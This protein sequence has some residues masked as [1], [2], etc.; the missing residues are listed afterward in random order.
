MSNIGKQRI[1]IPKNVNVGCKAWMLYAKGPY[2]EASI[3]FPIHTKITHNEKYLV[4][5]GNNINSALYGSLQR[6]LKSL[7]YGL[8]FLYVAHLKLVGVG[9]RASLDN[10]TIVLRL[11]FS[12]EISVLIPNTL[13]VSVSKRTN[14]KIVGS[15]LEELHQF[16]Y[17]L[18]SYRVPE[19]FKG[20]GLVFHGEIIRRKEGKKKK[21]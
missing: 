12:H 15:N 6:K 2:G 20:K 10:N 3:R 17:K 14:L 13:K 1:L 11:G 4:L 8:S 9:Y 18:R 5:D 21:T 19:P 7:L 16:A